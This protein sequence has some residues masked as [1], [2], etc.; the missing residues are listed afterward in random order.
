[1][2]HLDGPALLASEG[3]EKL[4]ILLHGYGANG[5]DLIDLAK[6]WNPMLP[7]VDFLSPHA[8]DLCE[9]SPWG[10]QWFSLQNWSPE[11]I[12]FGL[13]KAL[14]ALQIYIEESLKK[15]NLTPRDLALVGFSQGCMLAL[16]AGLH[17][18]FSP[19]C[20]LGYSG[21]FFF[22][23]IVQANIRPQVMLIH[24]DRDEVVPYAALDE[25]RQNLLIFDINAEI[26]TSRGLAHGIDHEGLALGGTFLTK[27]L[28]PQK[29][30][31]NKEREK[32]HGA[33]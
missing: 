11:S 15:R 18:P 10:R 21:A 5:D 13:K 12:L 14:P 16:Y 31:A 7:A 17:M 22:D 25:A 30:P 19:A 32:S 28:Y 23:S 27:C 1:M 29:T 20:I 2:S 6:A 26:H 9:I 24:G 4:V 8:P 33:S 3:P